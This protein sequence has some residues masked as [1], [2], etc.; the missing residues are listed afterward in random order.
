M[1]ETITWPR[2]T[3]SNAAGGRLRCN[4]TGDVMGQGQTK[5]YRIQQMNKLLRRMGLQSETKPKDLGSTGLPVVTGD[6]TWAWDRTQFQCPHCNEWRSQEGLLNG[7][8]TCS[9]P[10]GC[11]KNFRVNTQAEKSERRETFDISEL[12][13]L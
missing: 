7:V 3:F 5:A 2:V 9:G 10:W 11:R 13:E 1:T 4:Q 8:V 12:L 6:Y